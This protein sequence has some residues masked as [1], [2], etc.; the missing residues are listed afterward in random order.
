MISIICWKWRC[1]SPHRDEFTAVDVNSF[2]E[3]VKKN[4][5]VPYKVICITDDAEGIN[6]DIKILPIWKAP[7]VKI[8][9]PKKPNCFVRLRMFSEEAKELL[10]ERIISIDLDCVITGNI[11]HLLT[12]EEDF[13]GWR[14]PSG[15]PYQGSLIA[16]KT[17][18]RKF[19]WEEFNP[20][21]SPALA[22]TKHKGSDQ[23]WISY[24]LP[25]NEAV[26]TPA[27]DGVYSFKKHIRP[28]GGN[29]PSNAC[30]VFFHGQPKAHSLGMER[31]Y[32]WIKNYLIGR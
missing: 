9:D 31:G 11:D 25:N 10:G 2:Y 29:L 14:N 23:A 13:I 4:V 24:K 18:T 30:L 22:N 1:N 32:H 16:H 7:K 27:K 5:T 12:R 19:L 17:G 3:M 15:I 8:L 26:F 20:K 28:N 6:P 21:T